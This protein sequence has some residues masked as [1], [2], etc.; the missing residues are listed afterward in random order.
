MLS[1]VNLE[2]LSGAAPLPAVVIVLERTHLVAKEPKNIH[3]APQET[4]P[5][6]TP[7][8]AQKQDRHHHG[9]TG[10]Q[11]VSNFNGCRK[12]YDVLDWDRNGNEHRHDASVTV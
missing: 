1:H 7:P 11:Q 12:N 5:N 8:H 9:K 3:P 4:I 2:L 10:K 6:I